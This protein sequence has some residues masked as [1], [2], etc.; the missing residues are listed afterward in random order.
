MET[1]S[2]K[3]AAVY[4]KALGYELVDEDLPDESPLPFH[5][6]SLISS[7]LAES[8]KQVEERLVASGELKPERKPWTEREENTVRGR[9]HFP[10]LTYKKGRDCRR[11]TWFQQ[12]RLFLLPYTPVSDRQESQPLSLEE[13]SKM[14]EE[15]VA[16]HGD[17]IP[18]KG[19][20]DGEE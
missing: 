13:L 10:S 17:S 5:S 8:Q 3:E 18:S 9:C 15:V 16:Q 2:D 6:F 12:G 20:K 7:E 11:C 4:R 14:T 1:E 19:N